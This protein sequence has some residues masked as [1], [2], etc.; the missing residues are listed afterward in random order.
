MKALAQMTTEADKAYMMAGAIPPS[1]LAEIQKNGTPYK[2]QTRRDLVAEN[3]RLR[4]ELKSGN[5][6]TTT[7][8]TAPAKL[9]HRQKITAAKKKSLNALLD[10]VEARRKREQLDKANR[11]GDGLAFRR[12][13]KAAEKVLNAQQATAD[14]EADAAEAKATGKPIKGV[15][16]GGSVLDQF[17]SMP[18]GD[19]RSAFYA[20]HKREILR[21]TDCDTND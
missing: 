6:T 15:Q 1:H 12:E 2:G 10:S 9:T 3:K 7:T 11:F 13:L 16:T 14:A 21:L 5:D 20:E 8:A 19:E 18:M 17:K 4:E